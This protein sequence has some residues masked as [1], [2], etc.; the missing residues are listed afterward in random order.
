MLKCSM[1][2]KRKVR[3]IRAHT[4]Q[5]G[6]MAEGEVIRITRIGDDDKRTFK[7]TDG[8]WHRRVDFK[9]NKPVR[10]KKNV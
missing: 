6:V 8:Y 10:R 1:L 7:G 9:V 2:L 4:V 3:C 5:G